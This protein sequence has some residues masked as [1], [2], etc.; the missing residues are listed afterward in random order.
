MLRIGKFEKVSL[1]R[2]TQDWEKSFG[3]SEPSAEQVYKKISLPRRA[4]TGSAGYDFFAPKQFVLAP[5]E[6][7]KIPTGIRVMIEDGWVL[8]CFPRSSLGFQYRLQM[9]N[10][11]G[12]ID[13]DYSQSDNEGHIFC[14]LTNDSREGKELVLEAGAGF[15]Q[16]IFLP[17]G[18]TI[19]DSTTQKRNGGF[20]ST[21]EYKGSKK[22]EPILG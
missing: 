21:N 2:F 13:S 10:T 9:D 18:I 16:G 7:L 3:G 15:M 1:E 4:T 17:F 12:I 22:E 11:V 8:A 14:K 6:T 19:D 20:G 5:G